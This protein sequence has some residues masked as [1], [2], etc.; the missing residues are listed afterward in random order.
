MR[1]R[2]FI[3]LLGGAFAAWSLPTSAQPKTTAVVGFLGT[4]SD[5]RLTSAFETQLRDLGWIVGQNLLIEYRWAEGDLAR[6]PALVDELVRLK[7]DL[8]LAGNNQA[9]ITMK[10]A[11]A[12][13]PIVAPTLFDPIG[14]GLVASLARPGGNVT[15]IT[16]QDTLPEKNLELAAEAIRG[17]TQM[18][19]LFNPE[20][21]GHVIRRKTVEAAAATLAIRLVSV[22]AKLPDDLGA[23]FQ[24][25]ARQRVDCVIVLGEPMFF[26]ERRRIAA[27][28]IEA[29]LPTMFV[30]REHVEAGGLMSYGGNLRANFQHA[31]DYVDK[32]LK[33]AKPADL[34]VEL[35]TRL[36]LVINLKTAKAIGLSIPEAFLLRADE[37]IE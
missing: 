36:E 8:M 28:A 32:I 34:P 11:T 5:I 17:A 26:A 2:Q 37:V 20:F 19:V 3:T 35:P 14:L 13:I 33:G 15:G 25:M 7:P 6:L 22:E 4:A 29:R 10:Q 16:N 12:V 21:Q 24:S 30:A 9:A 23:A 18:G 1:R 31:A 27:L